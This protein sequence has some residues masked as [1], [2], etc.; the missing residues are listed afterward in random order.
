VSDRRRATLLAALVCAVTVAGCGRRPATREIAIRAFAFAPAVDTVAVGDTVVWSNHDVV[1][2]TA[3]SRAGR[4]DS[5]SIDAGHAWS[6]VTG[7]PG[8]F[9]YECTLHP[10]MRGTLL[11]VR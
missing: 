5:G 3:T 9:E 8:T 1:P 10:T 11:V 2:H 6:Y 7:V 4:F